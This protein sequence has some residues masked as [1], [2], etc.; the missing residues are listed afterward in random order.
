MRAEP[1]TPAPIPPAG[2]DDFLS[3]T[4]G[5]VHG[6]RATTRST[7]AD[8]ICDAAA[9]ATL[10]PWRVARA[11]RRWPRRK[12]L[13]LGI[14]RTDVP[15]VLAQAR[16]A[17]QRSRHEVTFAAGPAG[18]RGKFQNLN[19]LLSDH[20]AA[21]HDWLLLIDDDVVLPRGF[22][23][24]FVFLA[25][26]FD[27]AL[28]QPAHRWRSHAAWQVTRR[29]P[30]VLARQTRFVEI[31]PVCALRAATFD[32][33]LPFPDLQFGWGLDLHWSAVA[34]ARGWREG[35][36]DATPVRHGLRRIASSYDRSDA[37]AETRSFLASR[38]YTPAADAQRSI[39][40][41]RVL[42]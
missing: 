9:L 20:P 3:G 6:V 14:E 38:P 32:A 22:L 17:L 23:D 28:A 36:I 31:G 7:I 27:F 33:L 10:V 25:E 18:E 42:R 24:A 30:G 12:V 29:R 5:Q 26:R 21:G 4:S 34:Q 19:Q 13:A 2:L 37:V 41:H 11:A 16:A 8:A 39:V 40:T 35:I 15:N 1:V